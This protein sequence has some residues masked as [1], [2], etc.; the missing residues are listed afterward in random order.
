MPSLLRRLLPAAGLLAAL[1]AAT[2]LSAVTPDDAPNKFPNDKA[3][4][5]MWR[6]VWFL[7]SDDCEGRGIETKGINLAADHIAAEFKKAGL[8]PAGKGGSYFQP[9][10]VT[11][12]GKLGTP[13]S[14]TLT[15]PKGSPRELELQKEFAVLGFSPS[16]KA[17]GPLAFAGYGITAPELKYDDY[18]GLDVRG[19]IVVV[20]RHTP[21]AD[22]EGDKR[23]DPAARSG[24]QSLHAPVSA[25]ITNAAE[26][27]A[28]GLIL[29]NDATTAAAKDFLPDYK[30]DVKGM[31]GA[32][33]PVL[34][35][36]RDTLDAVLQS[37]TGK[38]LE[39]TED[40]IDKALKP[41][42]CVLTGRKADITVTA[43]RTELPVKNVVGYLDG[44]GPLA[45]ETVVI[46]A[47]YDHLG[48][49]EEGRMG[50]KDVIGKIHHGA[51]DNASGTAG[52][53]ELAR[54]FAA[55]KNREGRRVV[56][57]AFTGE[58]RGLYGSVWYCRHPAFPMG[59]TAAMINLDMIGRTTPVPAD[60]LGAFGKQDRLMIYGTG[61]ADTFPRLVDTTTARHDFR[62]FTQDSGYGPSDHASFYRYRVPV[63][64]F[65]TGTH[66]EY[67]R[68]TDVA[69]KINV[70]GMGKVVALVQEFADHLT[71]VPTRPEYRP[72]SGL[73]RDPSEPRR[74]GYGA[75][76]GT[77]P[78]YTY[79]GEGVLLDDVTPG[80]PA[81]TA[82]LRGGDVI[83]E[84]NGKPVK[85]VYAYHGLFKDLRPGKVVE[86][87]VI[88]GRKRVT[89]QVTPE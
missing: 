7:A 8:K 28:A 72:T 49:G 61:T 59:K 54:R 73:W 76:L 86:L 80:G 69:E 77:Q 15:G 78:S 65:Y 14:L 19:K 58:E 21:R 24:V 83:I 31:D 6:D 75:R 16:A 30:A 18:A 81:D 11:T 25:K 38:T 23:F 71:T 37:A 47:H 63:L 56:F 36:K 60:W 51:D 10:T 9:F 48:L 82:G 57:V 46:G 33:F 42:S 20:L 45:D 29:V 70:V 88:R 74:T 12:G 64:F 43:E 67:H 4:Q 52:V 1:A 66:A 50:G 32:P 62:V 35:I 22:A 5:R 27:G 79:G 2:P 53:M 84:V 39:A 68:P 85:D 87:E 13:T 40:A 26:H 34:Q 3:L 17:S 55:M 89:F 41:S 44:S